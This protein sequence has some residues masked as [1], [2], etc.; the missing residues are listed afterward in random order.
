MMSTE[1]TGRL[2]RLQGSPIDD[3]VRFEDRGTVNRRRLIVPHLASTADG[4]P[5]W[6]PLALKPSASFPRTSPGDPIVWPIWRFPAADLDF[7]LRLGWAVQASGQ[8]PGHDFGDPVASRLA[9]DYAAI[10]LEHT[11]ADGEIRRWA[12][13]DPAAF[14]NVAGRRNAVRYTEARRTEPNR[15]LAPLGRGRRDLAVVIDTLRLWETGWI[16][17]P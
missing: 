4:G 1:N 12:S 7:S 16:R 2:L 3:L 15:Q 13:D 17:H 6:R 14:A 5:H 11:D 9:R 10:W 8:S